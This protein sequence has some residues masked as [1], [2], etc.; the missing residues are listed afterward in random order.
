MKKYEINVVVQ[1]CEQGT[2]LYSSSQPAMK[3][4]VTENIPKGVDPVQH[5]RSR[6]KEEIKRH[7]STVELDY[8]D[9]ENPDEEV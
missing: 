1:I 7:A 6:L 9:Q 2:D 5:L 8:E 3:F 4:S